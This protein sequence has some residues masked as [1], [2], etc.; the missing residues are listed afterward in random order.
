[1]DHVILKICINLFQ[2]KSV[3]INNGYYLVVRLKK[4][5]DIHEQKIWK[6][7]HQV[8]AVASRYFVTISMLSRTIPN[9]NHLKN[10]IKYVHF[11]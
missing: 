1:M 7:S 9:S 8:A 5:S 10:L 11:I 3:S 2:L 6:F 4:R